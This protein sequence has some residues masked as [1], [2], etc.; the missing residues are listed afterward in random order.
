MAKL[1]DAKKLHDFK[2]TA[3]RGIFWVSL[4]PGILFVLGSFLVSES[5]RWLFRRGKKD[6]ALRA[7]L[8]SRSEEQARIEMQ[9]MEELASAQKTGAATGLKR[10]GSIFQRKYII[11]F[12]LACIVLA[13]NQATGINSIIIYNT[14]VL[15]QAGLSDKE[16]HLGYVIFTIVNFL[17]TIIAIALVDRKGRKFLLSLGTAGVIVSLLAIGLVFKQTEEG[18]CYDDMRDDAVQRV[19]G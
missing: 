11:P 7:L 18:D 10:S 16:A 8:R 19:N 17:M 4:P 15:I 14:T 12:V 9:E 3:W 6:A 2:D 13:C 1:G 5:P